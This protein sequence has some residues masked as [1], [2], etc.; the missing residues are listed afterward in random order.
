MTYWRVT[1]TNG[2]EET[3]HFSDKNL[4]LWVRMNW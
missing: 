3:R 1:H 4:Q 2:Y